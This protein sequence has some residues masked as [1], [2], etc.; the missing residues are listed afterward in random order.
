MAT[1]TDDEADADG[2]SWILDNSTVTLTSLDNV[3]RVLNPFSTDASGALVD[4]RTGLTY[5]ADPNAWTP[6]NWDGMAPLTGSLAVPEPT[7][8]VMLLM[9]GLLL[10][11][12]RVA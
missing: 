11:R 4:G 12:R 7:G 2:S 5:A 8:L 9:S 3:I 10:L 6:S 1:F